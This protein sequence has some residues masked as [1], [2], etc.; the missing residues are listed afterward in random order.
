M[1]V[2]G[3]ISGHL[4]AAREVLAQHDSRSDRERLGLEIVLVALD[5][6]L[7]LTRR[8]HHRSALGLDDS[9]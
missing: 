8:F 1:T 6:V 7:A 9:R 2:F 5:S 3:R 4:A